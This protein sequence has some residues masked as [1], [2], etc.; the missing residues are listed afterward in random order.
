MSS[1]IHPRTR[2]STSL[3]AIYAIPLAV[4]L[5]LVPSDDA[6]AQDADKR[7]EMFNSISWTDA[8]GVGKLGDVARLDIPEGER[9]RPRFTT[10]LTR[11]RATVALVAVHGAAKGD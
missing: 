9:W 11:V 10:R 6:D 2:V 8:P 1:R 7:R 3:Q 4:A 5:A